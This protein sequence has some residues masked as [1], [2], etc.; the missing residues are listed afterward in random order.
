MRSKE[1]REK[2]AVDS[3]GI[4]PLGDQFFLVE[5]LSA[6]CAAGIGAIGAEDTRA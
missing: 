2:R 5:I 6:F 4:T 3:L 1:E